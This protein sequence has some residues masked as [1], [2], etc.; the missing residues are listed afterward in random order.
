M[1]LQKSEK[2]KIPASFSIKKAH[3]AQLKMSKH[4]IRQDG[5]SKKIEYVTG[6]DVAY[7]NE[8]SIGA[9]VTL[10]YDS[11]SVIESKTVQTRTE[12]PYIPTLLSFREVPP[13]VAAAK[14][15]LLQPDV[16]LVDGQGIM[17]PYRLGFASHLGLV[18]NKPTIG[19]AKKP[20]IGRIGEYNKENWAP[21]TDKQE[22]VGTALRTRNKAKPVYVSVGHMVSLNRAIEIVKHCSLHH[23]I[24]KPIR[25][26]HDAATHAKQKV[27]K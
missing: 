2:R 21:I 6:V 8:F 12:F 27:Q 19:I 3:S 9:V 13:A 20:L 7:T 11:L 15:L 5:L 22:V 18:L 24:P 16:F 10:D 14:K 1:T 25:L 26:A 17:H 4:V 23:R